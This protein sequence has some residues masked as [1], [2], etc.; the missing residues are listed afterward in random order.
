MRVLILGS[1]VIG[2]L[3]GSAGGE[4]CA[5]DIDPRACEAARLNGIRDVREGDLFEPIRDERFDHVAFNPPY[6][7]GDP[8]THPLGQALFDG[9]N[10]EIIRRYQDQ[11]HEYW[12]YVGSV[13][14]IA[15]PT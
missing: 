4:I 11:V 2:V 14:I 15:C 12:S 1:G 9:K 10:F 13:P 5:T 3:T 7:V 6:F 8:E